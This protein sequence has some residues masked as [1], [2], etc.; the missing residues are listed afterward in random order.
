MLRNNGLSLDIAI[1]WSKPHGKGHPTKGENGAF[2]HGKFK[3]V[4][5]DDKRATT[6]KR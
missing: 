6:E 2:N 1:Q 3:V 5:Y 4:N